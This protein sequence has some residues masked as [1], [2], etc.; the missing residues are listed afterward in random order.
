MDN[1]AI[2]VFVA[3]QA[4]ALSHG[5]RRG[6]G[7]WTRDG[8]AAMTAIPLPPHADARRTALLALYA[9]LHEHVEQLDGRVREVTAEHRSAS[10]LMTHPGVGPV[11][12]LATRSK[13]RNSAR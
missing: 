9:A 7:L 11:T 5:V 4:I 6:P 13:R 2:I 12:A 1:L 10:L 8:Q 3:L